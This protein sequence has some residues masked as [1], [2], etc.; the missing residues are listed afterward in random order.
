MQ[1]YYQEAGGITIYHGNCLE[2]LPEL[3]GFD[4]L[5]T[6]P[7]YSSGGLF[8]SD[9]LQRTVDKYERGESLIAQ[10]RPDF[11]GDNRDQRAYY[12]WC[13]LWLAF[14]LSG[15]RAGAHAL[16][17]SDWRQVPTLSDALQAGGWLWRGLATWHKPGI[18]MQR[19]GF[20]S[21][22]EYVLWGT[23]GLWNHDHAY[24][25]QNVM[26]CAPIGAEEKIHLAEKPVPVLA[27]LVQFAPPGAVVCDPFMGSGPT[28]RAAKD[29]GRQAIGIDIDERCCEKAADRLRQAVL[30]WGAD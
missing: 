6:D 2:V 25:P 21:S 18:R 23:A 14:A 11:A 9:R 15:A 8:R 29:L 17:F 27:W 20:S 28:L 16:I 5:V 10:Q 12:A 3:D 7:P 13:S 1:P 30:P 19:G 26:R 22:A 4:A 24:A